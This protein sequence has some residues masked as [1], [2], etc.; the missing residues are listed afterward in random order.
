MGETRVGKVLTNQA[1]AQMT[2][3]YSTTLIKNIYNHPREFFVALC[4]KLL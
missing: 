3:A 4:T 1:R 2:G